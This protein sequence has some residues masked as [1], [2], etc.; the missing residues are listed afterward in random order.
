M[1]RTTRVSH[2]NN[3]GRMYNMMRGIASFGFLLVV[4]FGMT[5]EN[6]SADVCCTYKNA[7]GSM[8]YVDK[9]MCSV[10]TKD[11]KIENQ[12]GPGQAVYEKFPCTDKGNKPAPGNEVCI[13]NIPNDD[14][15]ADPAD[16]IAIGSES[17]IIPIEKA[18]FPGAIL[19]DAVL[20]KAFKF[21]TPDTVIC[22]AI[23]GFKEPQKENVL[24][25]SSQCSGVVNTAE[26]QTKWDEESI[27][28]A[29]DVNILIKQA[30]DLKKGYMSILE[31]SCC[32]PKEP[33]AG[34]K[35][36]QWSDMSVENVLKTEPLSLNFDDYNKYLGD[37]VVAYNNIKSAEPKDVLT[38]NSSG[39]DIGNKS[40]EDGGLVAIPSDKYK[41]WLG[42]INASMQ[43]FCFLDKPVLCI[44][45]KSDNTVC[46]ATNKFSLEACNKNL[47]EKG[48]SG[49]DWGCVPCPAKID[50]PT[51]ADPSLL[52]KQL[53]KEAESL[54]PMKF[55]TGQQGIL[56]LVGRA[57]KALMYAMGSILFALYIYAGILW[58]SS[59]GNTERVGMAKKIVVWST[60]GVIVQLSAYMIVSFVFKFTGV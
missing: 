46:E 19:F 40:C 44:C 18:V 32:V 31:N 24:G 38:C 10:Q 55:K 11:G 48:K 20:L 59:A 36:T 47:L 16:C 26:F 28:A 30:D 42:G 9:G 35:Q 50:K 12:A 29:G 60:L 13:K 49:T 58:M 57:V 6:A 1:A 7:D 45:K 33:G 3:L 23:S 14:P 51:P 17:Q 43:A 2:S 41:D 4:F 8:N 25:S 15:A 56:E 54:N 37:L 39:Y 52:I 53:Q 22:P 34:C 5:S 27:K 21:T